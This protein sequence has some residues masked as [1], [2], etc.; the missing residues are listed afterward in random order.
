M[1]GDGSKVRAPARFR[2]SPRQTAP[3]SHK[4]SAR[5]SPASGKELDAQ[6]KYAR[7]DLYLAKNVRGENVKQRQK[8][9]RKEKMPRA[10]AS[11]SLLAL[12]SRSSNFR[13]NGRL[14]APYMVWG[15][16]CEF[17]RRRLANC[18]SFYQ[19]LLCQCMR[20]QG[21]QHFIQSR[22]F[23]TAFLSTCISH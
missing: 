10:Q 16:V 18:F 22:N 8:Q 1:S 12:P 3:S 14:G 23:V 4:I 15:V 7:Q 17:W 21:K 20:L 11:H 9:S 5:T 2:Q 19:R 6:Q 13:T